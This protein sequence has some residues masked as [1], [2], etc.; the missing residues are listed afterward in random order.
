MGGGG[1]LGG[2]L[3]VVG[4]GGDMPK[5][6]APQV[7]VRDPVSETEEGKRTAKASRASLYSTEGGIQGQELSP[8][9]VKRR[10]TLLGN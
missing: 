5:A 1:L 3:S 6:Q 7:V 8:E 4:L 10:S 2:L 9:Q